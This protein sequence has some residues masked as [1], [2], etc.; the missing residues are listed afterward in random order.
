MGI[1]RK[2]HHGS[3]T[4]EDPVSGQGPREAG[5]AEEAAG[6]LGLGPE[7]GRQRRPQNRLLSLQGC[8]AGPQDV[9]AAFREQTS[10]EPAARRAAGP[11]LIVMRQP[12]VFLYSLFQRFISLIRVVPRVDPS[13]SSRDTDITILIASEKCS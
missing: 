6:A 1:Q 2:G 9:Q 10:K 3:R 13:P 8:D 12:R 5:Q 7:E 11:E 4:P